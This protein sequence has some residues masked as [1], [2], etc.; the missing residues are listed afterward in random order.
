VGLQRGAVDIRR[1]DP[2]AGEQE[3]I[4]R[5]AASCEGQFERCRFAFSR[6]IGEDPRKAQLVASRQARVDKARVVRVGI[7]GP[8]NNG[9]K[10]VIA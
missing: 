3:G 5:L 9:G 2:L 1:I 10:S 6:G 8:Q 7:G 4:R